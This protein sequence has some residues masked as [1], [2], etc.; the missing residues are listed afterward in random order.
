[1]KSL[2]IIIPAFLLAGFGYVFYQDYG[3]SAKHEQE[4]VE[5]A[6]AA[7]KKE[8]AEKEATEQKAREDAARRLAARED[9]EKKKDADRLAKWN[10]DNAAVA[11]DTAAHL[12]KVKPRTLEIA[13]LEKQLAN[14]RANTAR[15]TLEN[16]DQVQAN[17]VQAIEKRNVELEGLQII[18]HI[19][20]RAATSTAIIPAVP[21]PPAPPAQ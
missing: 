15:L 8:R 1:M 16:F 14:L 4:R 20:R 5:A 2:Y 7:T 11:A 10:A 13:A 3:I 6:A 17:A 12:A 9:A 18:A 21:P 19:A